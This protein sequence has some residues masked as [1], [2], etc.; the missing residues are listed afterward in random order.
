VDPDPD[1]ACLF[2]ADAVRNL[3]FTL[4]RIWILPFNLM[5]IRSTILARSSYSHGI[6]IPG[7]DKYIFSEYEGG[8]AGNFVLLAVN[9]YRHLDQTGSV[10]IKKFLIISS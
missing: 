10:Q 4:M 9:L 7:Y 2:D 8:D 6:C 3:A 1:P 5:R